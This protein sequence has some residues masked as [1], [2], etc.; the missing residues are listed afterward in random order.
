MIDMLLYILVFAVGT[1]LGAIVATPSRKDKFDKSLD[2]D[3]IQGL[4]IISDEDTIFTDNLDA[5]IKSEENNQ[6]EKE[7]QWQEIQ[8]KLT[9]CIVSRDG[10]TYIDSEDY[11]AIPHKTIKKVLKLKGY[12]VSPQWDDWNDSWH[13]YVKLS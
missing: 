3:A 7:R 2:I 6:A 5:I 11:P 12:K 10:A 8:D 13:F 4:S 9:T 1:I